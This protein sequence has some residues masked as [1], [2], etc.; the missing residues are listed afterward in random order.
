MI[1]SS[2]FRVLFFLILSINILYAQNGDEVIERLGLDEHRVIERVTTTS[3]IYKITD[4]LSGK[5]YYKNLSNYKTTIT[6]NTTQV[7]TTVIYPD[8][9]DTTQFSGMYEY[10]TSVPVGNSGPFPIIAGDVNKNG[11]TELYG[12]R[13]NT[14]LNINERSMYE[15]NPNLKVFEFKTDMPWDSLG[16]Y[17][18]FKQIYDINQDGE[19]NVFITGNEPGSDTLS[20]IRVARTLKVNDSTNLPTDILFDYKQWNQMNDP[21]WGEYDNKEG[22]DL[23]YC[24]ESIDLRVAAAKY[25]KNT[26]TA[27]TVYVYLVPDSIFYLAGLSNWDIDE[28]GYA[29]LVTGGLRGDIVIFEYDESIQNYR[30]VWYGDGGTFNVY[31]HFNTNDIDGNGKKEIWVGGDATYNGVPKTRLTCLEAIGDN[32]YMAKHVIDIVGRMSFDAYNGFAVDIDKDG[33]DEIGLCLDQTFMIFE[34]KGS[35]D[36]WGFD[37]FYLKLN[38]IVNSSYFGAIMQDANDDDSEEIL[39]SMDDDPPGLGSRILL[40]RVYKPTGLVGV[41]ESEIKV[42]S[43]K[44]FQNY[45]NPFNPSTKIKYEIPGQS[46]VNISIFNLIGEKIFELVNEEKNKGEYS[47]TFDGQSFPSGV[48]FI[49]MTAGKYVK[50]IKAL[51]IK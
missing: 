26:N 23:F 18:S 13:I 17:G 39:V 35:S 46:L 34:F 37:L 6:K 7:D 2:L 15:Y 29:D 22:T 31:I 45:P 49:K 14:Y 41:S 27:S 25:D 24:G 4:K 21:L 16:D 33:T 38:S 50:T 12:A 28:D 30:D 20:G 51:L 36:D 40:T 8:L 5:V 3:E 48:Y 10:W 19:E 11:R 9:V 47:I 1:V 32:Q 43:Y 44:L 42:F